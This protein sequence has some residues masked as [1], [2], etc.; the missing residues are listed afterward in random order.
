MRDIGRFRA[1][2]EHELEM[3]RTWR[4]QPSVRKNMY[5]QH[6]ISREEHA[7]WWGRLKQQSIQKYMMYE[8]DNKPLGVVYFTSID[9]S[10]LNCAWGFYSSPDAP[11]GTG[12]KMEF[13]A[14]NYAFNELGMHKLYCEVL[15]Y[16]SAVIKLHGKFGFAQ[17]G[18]FRQHFSQD[19]V[20]VDI[21]RLGMLS[22]EWGSLRDGM[23]QRIIAM[24][25]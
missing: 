17:E 20:F 21:V 25:K 24:S 14:L 8:Y 6:E 4:N 9:N 12:T 23:E 19:D 2:E 13:L 11:R 5:T 1:I 15:A 16:N 3:I 18:I 7:F 22:S 10:N